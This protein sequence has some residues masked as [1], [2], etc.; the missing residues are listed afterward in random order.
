MIPARIQ[1]DRRS[2]RE[3]E[4][5][6]RILDA[7]IACFL[8]K[9]FD[10][11]TIDE[12]ADRADVAR[13]TVFNHFGE[14]RDLLSAYLT[15]RREE[16]VELLR[17]EARADVGARQQLYDALDL[18]ATFNERNVAEARELIGAWW[19]SGG[20]TAREPYTAIVLAEVIAAGQRNGEFRS[21]IDPPL[22]GSVILDAYAGLLLRWVSAPEERPFSLRD[23][24]RQVCGIV[25]DGISTG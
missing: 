17:R 2:R 19:R 11:T 14:K 6:G 10:G 21:E 8:E 16:L 1:P 25:L 24:L 5:R 4:M 3:R 7:A 20:T 18:I 22:V 23:T 13:A 12:I 9:G 15:R